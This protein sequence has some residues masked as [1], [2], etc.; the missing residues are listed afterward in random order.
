MSNSRNSCNNVPGNLGAGIKS[1]LE[2]HQLP[3]V[4]AELVDYLIRAF[5]VTLSPDYDLRNYDRML[6]AQDVIRHLR[7]LWE[8]QKPTDGR[9]C[10]G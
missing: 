8:D 9:V 4:G 7:M 2:T 5:P 1:P 10:R 3:A 6:G